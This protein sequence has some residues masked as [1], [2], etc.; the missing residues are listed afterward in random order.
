MKLLGMNGRGN[1][2]LVVADGARVV[3]S[4]E[5][6]ERHELGATCERCKSIVKA[7]IVCINVECIE[8]GTEDNGVFCT[9]D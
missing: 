6:G 5:C 9:S 3:C 2:L 8:R 7:V 4:C 1:D